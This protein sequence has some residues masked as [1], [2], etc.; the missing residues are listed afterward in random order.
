[1]DGSFD[2]IVLGAGASGMT[3][4]IKAAERKMSVLLVEKG[5]RQ[6]RKIAASGNGRCNLINRGIPRYYGSPEFAAKVLECCPVSALTEFFSHYG[7]LLTEEN[8]ERVYPVTLRSD[9]VLHALKTALEMKQVLTM[10]DTDVVSACKQ[11]DLFH[12]SFSD[13]RAFLGRNLVISCG[14]AAQPRLGGSC[15]GYKMLEMFGHTIVPVF[16]A[17]VPLVSDRKSI[18]GLA[19]RQVHCVVSVIKKGNVIHSEKGTVLFTDYGLSGICAMQCARFINPPDTILELDFLSGIFASQSLAEEE[20]FRR[21]SFFSGFSPLNLI[22][23]I[24]D[25]KIG[26][27]IMKQAGIKMC[28]E[29][30]GDL[31]DEDLRRVIRTA[32]HYRICITGSKGFDYAQVTAGGADCGEFNPST[33][34]SNLTRGLFATGEVLNVDGDCGGFNLMFAFSSGYLAGLSVHT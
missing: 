12:V 13:G 5:N 16:P 14:G 11:K 10:L 32:Y 3:A 31:T 22:T 34:E 4:A 18:S 9:S 6:G 26:F 23:G 27:A 24:V 21:R 29:T 19:G 25:E 17:L 1:M 33:M 8:E 2:V 28:G 20:A 7:L 30:A 15:D